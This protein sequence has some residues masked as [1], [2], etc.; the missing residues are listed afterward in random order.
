M[1]EP[2][3]WP[4]RDLNVQRGRS[5]YRLSI[6]GKNRGSRHILT[7][8][9]AFIFTLMVVSGCSTGAQTF[10]SGSV[11]SEIAS[12]EGDFMSEDKAPNPTGQQ[13]I[14]TG[15]I[16]LLA[17]NTQEVQERIHT[18]V[19]ELGG[20][21]SQQ[22]SRITDGLRYVTMTVRVPDANLDSF[23]TEVSE[24]GEVT[25]AST[26]SVD[27][28]LEVTDLQARIDSLSTTIDR[29]ND[30]A[31]QATNVSDLVAVES[32]LAN[33]TSE[34][35]SLLAQQKYLSNQV[36]Q[37]TVYID[38]SPTG[39]ATTDSPDFL[40]G[41]ADGWNSLVNFLAGLIT[42]LG[43]VLPFLAAIVIVMAIILGIRFARTKRTSEKK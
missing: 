34:R 36:A 13:L 3:L 26:T 42:A 20:S 6:M 12:V 39:T 7:G 30:L 38:L 31:E 10:D 41:L 35:D 25:F 22:E 37:S 14:R 23:M 28:T 1:T 9:G 8:I 16:S 18:V 19:T 11:N 43:F 21:V 29:L 32:E 24:L 40:A 15:S 17:E 2:H 4:N 5:R 33:R 27:V